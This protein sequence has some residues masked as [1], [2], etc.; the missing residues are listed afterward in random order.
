MI[1]RARSLQTAGATLVLLVL[2]GI[3][4]ARADDRDTPRPSAGA[5][6]ASAFEEMKRL[7]GT[8]IGTSTRGWEEKITIKVIAGGSVLVFDSFEAHPGEEMLTT[9]YL[10]GDEL[11]LRHYCIAGNQPRLAATETSPDARMITFT[12]KDATNLPSRDRGHMDKVVYRLENNDHF[13][14]RWTWY[15]DGKES[16]LEEIR[17]RR[18][19]PASNPPVTRH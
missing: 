1:A 6:A 2:T 5:T 4:A 19:R 18:I 15:Q 14:S 7:A 13:S 9:Y 11:Q 8:W 17:Y 16:W 12:F 3:P 10:D